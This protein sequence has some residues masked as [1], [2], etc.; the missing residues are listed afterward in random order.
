MSKQQST[1]PSKE[2]DLL[3][4]ENADNAMMTPLELQVSLGGGDHALSMGYA[5]TATTS[6]TTGSERYLPHFAVVHPAKPG[7]IRVVFDPAAR[8]GETSLNDHLLPGPDLLRLL[9]G[10]I[11]RFCQY[12]IAVAADVQEMF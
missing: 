5:E 9:L 3:E 1:L 8:S 4:E 11:M 6:S 7:Q 2:R 10:V 12:E